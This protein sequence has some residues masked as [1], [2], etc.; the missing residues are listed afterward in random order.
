[1]WREWGAS[2]DELAVG[3]QRLPMAWCLCYAFPFYTGLTLLSR[4]LSQSRFLPSWHS[5]FY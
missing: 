1:M 3:E 5:L 4:P 2:D